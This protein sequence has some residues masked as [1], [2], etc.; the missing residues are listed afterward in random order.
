MSGLYLGFEIQGGGGAIVDNVAVGG[1]YG[2]GMCPLI[3]KAR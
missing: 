1:G 3:C 2:R